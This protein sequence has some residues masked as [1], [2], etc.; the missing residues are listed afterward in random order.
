MMM[1]EPAINKL[2]I[3]LICDLNI[4]RAICFIYVNVIVPDALNL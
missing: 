2:P 1:D 4:L 3:S